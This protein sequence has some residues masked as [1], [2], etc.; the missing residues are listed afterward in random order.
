MKYTVL[1]LALLGLGCSEPKTSTSTEPDSIQIQVRD[2]SGNIAWKCIEV[3]GG[4]TINMAI[5]VYIA[6]WTPIANKCFKNDK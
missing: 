3:G 2:S 4:G 5:P 1:I 6:M